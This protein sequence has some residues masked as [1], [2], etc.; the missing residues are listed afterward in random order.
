[1]SRGVVTCKVVNVIVPVRFL[2]ELPATWWS[3]VD[4]N[5]AKLTTSVIILQRFIM[6]Q[7]MGENSY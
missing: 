4:V 5:D 7:Q 3:E 1:M 6:Q 2:E